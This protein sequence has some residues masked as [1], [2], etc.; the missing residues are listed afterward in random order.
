MEKKTGMDAAAKEIYTLLVSKLQ[1]DASVHIGTLVSAAARLAGASLY[2][3]FNFEDDK[4]PPG[5]VVLSEEAN[6]EWPKL[7]NML[8]ATLKANGM[9]VD[10][11]K[12]VM[13]T[14]EQ[15]KPNK[16]ILEM[17]AELQGPFNQILGKNRL[18]YR[19]G[20]YAAANA[21]AIAILKSR[22]L[23][24]PQITCGLAALGFVEGSKTAPLPLDPDVTHR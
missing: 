2:R 11:A 22:L 23:V 14:P 15:H 9:Q 7:M 19:Q 4:V 6:Q 24:D 20:A 16:P 13:Q 8:L 3:S 17:Q 1:K 21:C 18:D 12:F 10:Q 5:T